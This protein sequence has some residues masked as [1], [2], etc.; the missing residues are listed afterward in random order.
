MKQELCQRPGTYS[1]IPYA[2]HAVV[3]SF[4]RHPPKKDG[5]AQGAGDGA[6]RKRKKDAS[7]NSDADADR[8]R[9]REETEAD[10]VRLVRE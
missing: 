9:I 5:R 1:S 10:L 2:Q 8:A 7:A 6:S 4:L 3:S